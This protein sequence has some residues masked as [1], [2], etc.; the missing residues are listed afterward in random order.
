MAS[1]AQNAFVTTRWSVVLG[2]GASAP[3]VRGRSLEELCRAY[4]Y[5]LYAFTRR[6]GHAASDAEDLT[7]SFF[8]YLITTGLPAR[9]DRTLGRF[10]SFLLGSFQNWLSNEHR[11]TH[12]AKRGA[13]QTPI[14]LDALDAEQR[15]ALEPHTDE[16]PAAQFER[17]WAETLI[18]ETLARLETDSGLPS[19][20]FAKMRPLLLG[21]T[22]QTYS[23]LAPELGMTEGALKV[24]VHRC[25][26]RFGELLRAT[27][28]DTVE[29][30]AEVEAE[31]RYILRLF[32]TPGR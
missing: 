31:L 26:K 5:P 21:G 17:A 9:A 13:G 20:K 18:S 29:D 23:Q 30:P 6:L 1:S 32:S 14:A 27:I 12:A 7:Q 3:E 25:R 15:Y 8:L 28:A 22:D 11:R 19:E 24:S 16:T 4:W 10:R 2:A